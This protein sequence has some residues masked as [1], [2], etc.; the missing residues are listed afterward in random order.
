MKL[1]LVWRPWRVSK[2]QW[3]AYFGS[4][5]QKQ[6]NIYEYNTKKL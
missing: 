1:N 6:F 2:T 5:F 4:V 3:A